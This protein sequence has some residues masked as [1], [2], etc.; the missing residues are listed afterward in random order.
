MFNGLGRSLRWE[1][2]RVNFEE[3]VKWAM[4]YL[5]KEDRIIWH[6][7][8]IQRAALMKRKLEGGSP[9]RSLDRKTKRIL[10]A[11]SYDRIKSDYLS[12]F[13]EQWEHFKSV[14]EVFMHPMMLEYRFSLKKDGRSV[15]KN[16]EKVLADFAESEKRLHA[17]HKTDRYCTDGTPYVDFEDGWKWVIVSKGKSSQEA[18]AMRHCGNG[19]GKKDDELLSLREPVRKGKAI[20]WKPHLTFILNNGHLGE[21]KGYANGKPKAKFHPRI[22]SLI[23]D[24]RIKG[25]RGGGFGAMNNFSF[26]DLKPPLRETVL[27]SNP[28]LA[29]DPIG[30]RGEKL[31]DLDGPE[32]WYLADR[33]NYP[34]L[35]KLKSL[36]FSSKSTEW[37]ALQSELK[38][39]DHSFRNSEGW[40]SFKDGSLGKPHWERPRSPGDEEKVFELLRHPLCLRVEEDLLD[41]KST[42]GT[43]LN[44]ERIRQLILEKPS[45]FKNTPIEKVFEATGCS[46]G[47]ASLI[48]ERHSLKT[49]AKLNGLELQAFGSLEEFGRASGVGWLARLLGNCESMSKALGEIDFLGLSWLV[50]RQGVKGPCLFLF[51][52]SI[53]HFLETMNFGQ[54]E[55]RFSLLNEI[56]LR[57]GPPDRRGFTQALGLA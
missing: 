24:P 31:I 38:I 45:L 23:S 33:V 49:R 4:R 15:P 30:N 16:P 12:V 34:E 1:G 5:S 40:C 21:M 47:F 6:L 42:W 37:M 27:G 32:N 13:R 53:I 26:A 48:N 54:N 3:R 55:S 56:I 43:F 44:A 35:A 50:L 10:K 41:P 18:T 52:D 17:S 2:K 36:S 29:F 39:N 19:F 20:L 28:R 46:P 14:Q 9:T 22:V 7:G 51:G 11:F 8:I 25:L 57:F